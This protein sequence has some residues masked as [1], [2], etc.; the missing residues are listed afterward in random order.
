MV[1]P[2]AVGVTFDDPIGVLGHELDGS[3]AIAWLKD[4]DGR[5]VYV[6]R[7]YVEALRVT[8]ERI[9]GHRDGDLGRHE[10]VDGAPFSGG[11]AG[12]VKPLHCEHTVGAFDGRPALTVVRFVVRDDAGEPIGICGLAAPIRETHIARSECARLMHAVDPPHADVAL[13]DAAAG[14]AAPGPRPGSGPRW[15]ARAQRELTAALAGANE[16]PAGLRETIHALGAHGGWD[17][18]TLWQPDEHKPVLRCAS[19]WTAYEHLRAFEIIT[20]QTRVPLAE[21]QLGRALFAPGGMEH[22]DIGN[23]DDDRLR[24]AAVR[25][26]R[27]ALLVPVR[28][29]RATIGALELLSR[30]PEALDEELVVAVE[31]IA[32]QLAHFRRLLGLV[33]SPLWRFGR[34]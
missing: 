14:E 24:A 10:I 13:A 30:S 18:V 33:A 25:G 28:D 6:N 20:W 5:Y 8:P 17:V 11:G 7:R 21:T 19:V 26:M 9:V 1:D 15:N 27:T 12:T 16:W 23:V 22:A 29:G 32:L 2:S 34:F 3:P 4:L 31:S